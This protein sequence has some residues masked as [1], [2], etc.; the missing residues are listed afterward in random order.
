ML[1]IPQGYDVLFILNYD[2]FN[3]SFRAQMGTI[4]YS[5]VADNL[6]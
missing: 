3:H 6:N 2:Y 1:V 4:D 5:I